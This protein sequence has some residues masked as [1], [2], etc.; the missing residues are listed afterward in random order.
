M[1]HKI[2]ATTSISIVPTTKASTSTGSSSSIWGGLFKTSLLFAL[3]TFVSGT[4][5]DIPADPIY[6]EQNWVILANSGAQNFWSI[7]GPYLDKGTLIKPIGCASDLFRDVCTAAIENA[8]PICVTDDCKNY[9][10]LIAEPNEPYPLSIPE[11]QSK[12]YE[13]VISITNQTNCAPAEPSLDPIFYRCKV[14][15]D[16]LVLIL[17]VFLGCSVAAFLY[18]N[19]ARCRNNCRTPEAMPLLAAPHAAIPNPQPI[20]PGPPLAGLRTLSDTTAI[21]SGSDSDSSERQ[22]D[23]IPFESDQKGF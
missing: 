1:R 14:V 21:S 3:P 23:D 8:L 18:T 2:I 15:Q 22:H 11:Y 13:Q 6:C 7:M 17:I 20:N 10:N 4:E 5:I 12:I 16:N 9:K 19:I